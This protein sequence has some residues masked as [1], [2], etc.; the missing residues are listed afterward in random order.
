MKHLFFDLDGTLVDS[1]RG[2]VNGFT[3]TLTKLGIAVPD[4]KTLKTFIGPP[5]ET[6]LSSFGNQDFV[7]KAIDI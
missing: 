1:S 6:S 2:I 3:V 7:N 5:L 4:E